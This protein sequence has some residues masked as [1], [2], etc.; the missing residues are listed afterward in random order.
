MVYLNVFDW[1]IPWVIASLP[2]IKE[3]GYD[4][5]LLSPMTQCKEGSEW[6]KLYQ[7]YSFTIGNR[8][9]SEDDIR[10][11]SAKC[12]EYSLKLGHDTVLRHLGALDSGLPVPHQDSD[13]ALWK[14]FIDDRRNNDKSREDIIYSGWGLAR[15]D[16]NNKELQE[17]YYRPFLN[18]LSQYFDF[19]RLDMGKH[20]GLPSEGCSFWEFMDNIKLTTGMDVL[21]EC[22]ETPSEILYQYTRYCKPLTNKYAQCGCGTVRFFESHDTYYHLEWGDGCTAKMTDEERYEE[23]KKLLQKH[24]HVMYFARPLDNTIFSDKMKALLHSGYKASISK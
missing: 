22:I 2:Y 20:F 14:Y 5:I 3:T 24:H 4:G 7:L 17:K 11:L 23:F 6:W 12:R 10:M 1:E 18:K 16:Y 13:H 21:A 9:G 15:L 19:I 8:N